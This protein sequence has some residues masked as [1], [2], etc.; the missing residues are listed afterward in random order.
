MEGVEEGKWD[1]ERRKNGR[2]RSEAERKER[3]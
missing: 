1:K 2:N 3:R